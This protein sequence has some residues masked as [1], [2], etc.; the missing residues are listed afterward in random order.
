MEY[1]WRS[2]WLCFGNRQNQGT[3][4]KRKPLIWAG[5]KII[6]QRFPV[7]G[8]TTVNPSFR[9]CSNHVDPAAQ[10]LPFT[11]QL[12]DSATPNTPLVW[13]EQDDQ[14]CPFRTTGKQ[15]DKEATDICG[16]PLLPKGLLFRMPCFRFTLQAG[17]ECKAHRAQVVTRQTQT[18]APN[19]D[20]CYRI[21]RCLWLILNFEPACTWF[22]SAFSEEAWKKVNICH[23][24]P[25]QNTV[26]KI[27]LGGGGWAEGFERGLSRVCLFLL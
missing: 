23:G 20:F 11:R 7:C 13:S 12:Q 15:I 17:S 26:F 21:H 22:W 14:R 25:M 4:L 19:Y 27:H 2:M 6:T 9:G 24:L 18:R 10:Q 5:A 16:N 1:G 3:V 8:T